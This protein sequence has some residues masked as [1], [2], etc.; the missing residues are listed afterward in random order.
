[1]ARTF[2]G[3]DDNIQLAIGGLSTVTFASTWVVVFRAAS[4]AEGAL[5]GV[6]NASAG[7]AGVLNVQANGTF[8]WF[9]DGGLAE[10]TLTVVP[11]DGWALIAVSK[12]AGANPATFR[13]YIYSTNTWTS[14]TTADPVNDG[15]A[16][17]AGSVR[18]GAYYDGTLP[19]FDGQ[20]AA[21]A[22]FA[23]ALSQ[24]EVE[25]LAHSLGGWR[26][27]GPAAMWVLDQHAV[28]QQVKDWAGTANQ[29]GITGTSVAG[30]S[31]PI[32]YGEP[33]IQ[34]TP[35]RGQ[36]AT[37]DATAVQAAAAIPEPGVSAGATT[38]PSSVTAAASVPTPD[39]FVGDSPPTLVQPSPILPVTII[40]AP[41]VTFSTNAHPGLLAP[42]AVVP[43]PTVDVPIN[44]GDDLTAAGQISFNGFRM[45][46]ESNPYRWKRLTG[47]FVDMPDVDNGNVPHPS[48]HGA[49]SG[50]KK[51]QARRVAYE[52]NVKG[53]RAEVE[54]IALNLLTGLP[55]PEADEE[56]PLAIRVGEQILV[57]QAA[58]LK[59]TVEIDR[60]FR[61]GLA[62]GYALWELSNPRLYSRELLTAV[63]P[64]GGTV[65]VFHAGNTTT[66]PT[67][68]CPGPTLNP[69]L[70]I[71]RTL[72]DGSETVVTVGFD[73]TVDVGELLVIDPFNGT[74]SV[75]EE[76]VGGTLSN[77]SLGIADLVLGRDISS[78][79]YSSADGTAPAA[80]ALWRHAY[81]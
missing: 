53:T 33:F 44:P 10:S 48:D 56:I 64:D 72:D 77:S 21:A 18:L 58:C 11:G 2:D 16:P 70:V 62:P 1:M 29:S 68:R 15:A 41:A 31:A 67:I 25:N 61:I 38:H 8:L 66:H 76:D 57:G 71:E 3:V 59:R 24:A 50:S 52:F 36:H 43:T 23:R 27:A 60:N 78:I 42:H 4:A 35:K 51:A 13:K 40:P 12:P 47:W 28:G 55:L 75:G 14:E 7:L 49:L 20:I 17:G 69:E 32:G 6:A 73:L 5:I 34:A 54:Q 39:V 45:G 9:G 26:D 80:T 37:A 30:S 22:I 79:T 19:F 46:G 65:D 81:I 74:A 63:V